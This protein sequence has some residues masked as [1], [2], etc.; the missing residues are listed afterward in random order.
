M[1][2]G[3][4]DPHGNPHTGCHS[5]DGKGSQTVPCAGEH[6]ERSGAC[7][8]GEGWPS[9]LYTTWEDTNISWFLLFRESVPLNISQGNTTQ[10]TLTFLVT[11]NSPYFL[12]AYQ[13]T[14]YWDIHKKYIRKDAIMV[15]TDLDWWIGEPW[16][17]CREE[18]GYFPENIVHRL[19]TSLSVSATSRQSCI[20]NG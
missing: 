3:T 7:L 16:D 1:R 11:K 17:G 5:W 18:W 12:I 20:Q 8:W 13:Q 2:I 10:L 6:S 14:R 4:E 9:V 15:V 19:H